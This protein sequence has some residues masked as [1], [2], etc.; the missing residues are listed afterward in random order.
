[1]AAITARL[2]SAEEELNRQRVANSQLQGALT[3]ERRSHESRLKSLERDNEA[4][5]TRLRQAQNTLDQIAA[6]AR[7]LNPARASAGVTTPSPQVRSPITPAGRP[8]ATS[9]STAART[10]VV[11][12]GDSLTRISK[13][14]YGTPTRWQAIYQA[15][16]E[17]LS[18]SN[19]LSPG[20]QLRIP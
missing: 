8:A 15:N 5:N 4:L 12:E 14:Y 2:R 6:A 1:M 18:E 10:H 11:V 7:V 13:L 20:Q 17:T 3:T 9:Q 16:R 19:A